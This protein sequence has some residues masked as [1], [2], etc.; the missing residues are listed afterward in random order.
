MMTKVGTLLFGLLSTTSLSVAQPVVTPPIFIPGAPVTYTPLHLYYTSPTGSDAANGLTPATAWA[1]PNHSVVC[2]DVIIDIAGT[3]STSTPI[4]FGGVL[5][6][7][8][9]SGGI[10]GTGGIYF[11]AWLCA[12]PDLESCRV[13]HT[14]TGFIFDIQNSNWAVEG[15]RIHG[16]ANDSGAIAVNGQFSLIHHHLLINNVVDTV[17]VGMDALGN[18]TGHEIP[19]TTAFDYTAYIGNIT[20]NAANQPVC[21]GAQVMVDPGTID[22]NAGTHYLMYGGFSYNQPNDCFAHSDV[23]N[24]MFDTWD[25]HGTTAQTVRMNNVGWTSLRFSYQNFIQDNNSVTG[26]HMYDLN[27]TSYNGNT[28]NASF[29]GDF[30][31]QMDNSSAPFISILRNISYTV[32][33]NPCALQIGGAHGP[34]SLANITFGSTGNE[35][36]GWSPAS[37]GNEICVFNGGPSGTN[38][39]ENP[40]FN[41]LTDLV[42]NRSGIPN[43]TGFDTVTKCMGYDPTTQV[44]T[45][46]SVIYDLT[47]TSTHSA[48]KGYQLPSTTCVTSGDIATLYPAWLKAMV[49]LKWHSGTQTITVENDLV[50]KPCSVP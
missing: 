32:G 23:E 27:N 46:P 39:A 35:N 14:S 37:P 8:S 17:G 40:S 45:N 20:Q 18:G 5:N 6:C 21:T 7:P 42:N 26:L 28:N 25:A 43:C 3:R 12:G 11:A 48:G 47:P 34:S 22:N 13:N 15:F 38:F 50:T 36:I 30:N 31:T 19:A 4:E 16:D 24:F 2:G 33:T 41:N 9:T 44:L 29:A 1:T 10:D 49:R